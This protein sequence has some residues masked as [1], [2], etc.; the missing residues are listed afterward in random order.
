V[1]SS[2]RC[3]SLGGKVGGVL[4]LYDRCAADVLGVAEKEGGNTREG[5]ATDEP[6]DGGGSKGVMDGGGRCG[7]SVI[8]E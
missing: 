4:E 8:G 7:V 1:R 5:R 6:L 3:N 2:G